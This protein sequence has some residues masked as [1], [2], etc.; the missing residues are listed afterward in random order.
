MQQLNLG[1]KDECDVL[2][3]YILA[4]VISKLRKRRFLLRHLQSLNGLLHIFI[5]MCEGLFQETQ[6]FRR[7]IN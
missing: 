3:L 2:S 4:R 1:R 5:C 6:C 7:I